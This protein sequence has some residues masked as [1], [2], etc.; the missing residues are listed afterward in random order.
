MSIMGA[1]PLRLLCG[2]F[3]LT[4]LKKVNEKQDLSK[5]P[6]IVCF[7]CIGHNVNSLN[8]LEVFL[9][10]MKNLSHYDRLCHLVLCH[11]NDVI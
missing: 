7:L 10:L 4:Q 3:S 8:S 5:V 11:Y 1:L 2:M 9:L 6:Y